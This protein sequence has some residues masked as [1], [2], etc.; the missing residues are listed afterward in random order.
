MSDSL[1]VAHFFVK[2]NRLISDNSNERR[3]VFIKPNALWAA[4]MGRPNLFSLTLVCLLKFITSHMFGGNQ[5]D[6]REKDFIKYKKR[7]LILK[8]SQ[9]LHPPIQSFFLD[10][11]NPYFFL[12][13]LVKMSINNGSI[14]P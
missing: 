4:L 11:F 3:C 10:T 6:D 9:L 1:R 12:M 2:G 14:L 8:Q 7:F 13:V 5:M